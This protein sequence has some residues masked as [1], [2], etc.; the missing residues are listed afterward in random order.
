MT[1]FPRLFAFSQWAND[2]LLAAADALPPE[3]L[4]RDLGGSFPTVLDTLRHIAWS[5]WR[6]LDR[7]HERAP[8]GADPLGCGDLAALRARW[9]ALA[10]DQREFVSRVTAAD[11]GR[12]ISYI[13][14]AG[15]RWTY[16]LAD[17]LRHVVNHGTYHRGQVAT[18]LRRL[19][20]VPPS[21]DYLVYVDAIEA[22]RG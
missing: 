1:D 15:E 20:L 17:M 7:W 10:A 8:A 5:E 6:W 2:Q 11:L 14:D 9:A 21:T 16:T 18:M 19:S 22:T 13:N 3:A 12:H 4:T